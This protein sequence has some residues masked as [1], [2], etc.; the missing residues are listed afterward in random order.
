GVLSLASLISIVGIVKF[1]LVLVAA[2]KASRGE[3]YQ[4]PLTINF[5]K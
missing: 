3:V 2:I 5:V 4:Y 1:V